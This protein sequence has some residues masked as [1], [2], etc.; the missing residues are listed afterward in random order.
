MDTQKKIKI[1]IIGSSGT[2]GS[3]LAHK[4]IQNGNNVNLSYRKKNQI[5]RLK[6]FIKYQ[7]FKEKIKFFKFNISNEK[8]IIKSIKKNYDIFKLTDILIITVAEQGEIENF[9]DT[10]IN[11]FKKTI[12]INFMFY[13][14]FFRNLKTILKKKNITIILFSGGGST[15]YRRNFT[16]YSISKLCLVKLTEILSHELKNKKTTFNII[17]PGIINSR[18]TKQILKN[19]NKISKEELIKINENLQFTNENIN[20]VYK[21]INFL[22]SKKGKLISGKFISSSWDKISDIN[23]KNYLKLIKSDIYTLRRK[24]N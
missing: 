2:I 17:A 16:S 8:S 18:M 4:Y 21:T 3:F 10:N 1:T 6:K 9:F 23:Q 13:L 11:K 20:K 15:S 14:L 7:K 24:E 5:L 19:K 12:S 22:N